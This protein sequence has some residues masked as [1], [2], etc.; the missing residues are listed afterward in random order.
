M[1]LIISDKHKYIFFHLPKNAGTSVSNFLLENENYKF[2]KKS[3]MFLLRTF[4]N[5][6]IAYN[7]YLTAQNIKEKNFYQLSIKL[8]NSHSSVSKIQSIIEP[9]IFDSYHKFVVVRNPFDRFVSRYL[10]FKKINK[11]FHNY[12]FIE[13]LK[14]DLTSGRIANNQYQFLLNKDGKIGVDTI[15][16]F[17]NIDTDFKKLIEKFNFKNEKLT[18]LNYTNNDNYKSFYTKECK[19]LIYEY[20]K[21]DLEFFNYSF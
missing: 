20:C 5:K 18:R 10:Y 2:F 21:K 7:F 1:S 14:W 16:R 4:K 9:V 13:F 12:E 6:N 11:K 3:I 8:F 19:N 17:E 15:L